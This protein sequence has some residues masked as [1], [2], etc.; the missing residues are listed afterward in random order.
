[1]HKLVAQKYIP[2]SDNKPTVN[3][4]NGIKTDNN[5]SNLEWATYSENL[6]HAHNTRLRKPPVDVLSKNYKRKLNSEQVLVIKYL[7]KLGKLTHK[8]IANIFDVAR[9]TISEINSGTK[10]KH[11]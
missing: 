6:A 2:N 3:H 9:S 1:M 5:I 8:E 10:W 11:I 7:L 4:L